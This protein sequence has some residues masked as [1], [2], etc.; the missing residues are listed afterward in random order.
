MVSTKGRYAL[1]LMIDIATY[2]NGNPVSLKDV[3]ARQDISVKYLEQVVALLV[4]GRLLISVRGNNGGYMLTKDV[5]SYNTYEIL[6][7]AE[8]S[9]APVACL[10][11]EVNIC[12]R[13]EGCTTIDYWKGYYDVIKKYTEGVSLLD[14]V[15]REK[16]KSGND[17]SI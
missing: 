1:R 4:K 11:T 14:L 8:G 10:Q 15:E 5:A 2:S 12:K 6:C 7:A 17:Y 13:A 16:N 9:L 3:S